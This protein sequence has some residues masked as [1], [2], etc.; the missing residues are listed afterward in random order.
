MSCKFSIV[1]L[2]YH[3]LEKFE[4][5][6]MSMTPYFLSDKI[7]EIIILDNGS[8][9]SMIQY[10]ETLDKSISK[11]NVIYSSKNLGV[12]GG[13]KILFSKAKGDIIISLDSDTVILDHHYFLAALEN[14]LHSLPWE[15][16][17]S[18]QTKETDRGF[19][20]LGGGGGNHIHYPSLYTG[21]VVNTIAREKKNEFV[22]VAEVAGWCHCF[23]RKLLDN[24]EMDETFSPFWGEDTDFCIQINNLGGRMAIF[25]RGVIH[26]SFSTCRDISKKKKQ[27]SQWEKVLTKWNPVS[28]Y[29]DV[30]WYKDVYQTET[31]IQDYL[32]DI[33]NGCGILEGRLNRRIVEAVGDTYVDIWDQ[34]Q[35]LT[36]DSLQRKYG[37]GISCSLGN[38][39]HVYLVNPLKLDGLD[40]EIDNIVVFMN[41]SQSKEIKVPRH[42]KHRLIILEIDVPQDP[43]ILLMLAVLK[44][45]SRDFEQI[46]LIGYDLPPFDLGMNRKGI[47][48]FI[49][50]G[51]KQIDRISSFDFT[52]V[53]EIVNKSP[54]NKVFRSSL[55]V[56]FD[57]PN[58]LCPEYSPRHMAPE[59]FLRIYE[60][61]NISSN[62]PEAKQFL[63]VVINDRDL[64]D[65]QV[66]EARKYGDV[67]Y[68]STNDSVNRIPAGVNFYYQM[69]DYSL[70]K[71]FLFLTGNKMFLIYDY[72][73]VVVFDNQKYKVE[74]S[75]NEFYHLS[76]YQ[77]QIMVMGDPSLFSFAVEDLDNP[78]SLAKFCLSQKDRKINGHPINP[79]VLFRDNFLVKIHFT[80]IWKKQIEKSGEDEIIFYSR[81]DDKGKKESYL[82]DFPLV[83]R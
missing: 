7:L 48:K 6:I 45:S 12:A 28:K 31:P 69:E 9:G 76:R 46:E 47:R 23:R 4:R 33:G 8:S 11:I 49:R 68:L 51:D 79:E 73:W 10:L 78:E 80:Y 77:N 43:Y 63:T 39:S 16:S 57:Y 32:T 44:L 62:V 70:L 38:S 15:D 36:L 13:R 3:N 58:I 24:V 18:P 35:Q 50:G 55:L 72:E 37:R 19:Y 20:L 54:F 66:Q 1:M 64:G 82:K 53:K 83:L 2:T 22:V 25:G 67:M 14:N 27:D 5:C 61:T 60:Q 17:Y 29:I 74:G 40:P 21:D 34:E 59:L 81:E 41:H 26:H 42:L 52:K 71:L 56:P 65:D 75:L 30:D